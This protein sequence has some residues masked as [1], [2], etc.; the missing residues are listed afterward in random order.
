MSRLEVRL[1]DRKLWATGD[2]L[3]RAELDLLLNDNAGQGE[4][5]TFL[6]DSGTEMTTMPAWLAK[7]WT[8]PCPGRRPLVPSTSRPG[9]RSVR[10][11]SVRGSLA[12]TAWTSISLASSW[13]IRTPLP[14]SAKPRP[15]PESSWDSLALWTRYESSSTAHRRQRHCTGISFS[16]PAPARD[17]QLRSDATGPHRQGQATW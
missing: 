2:V 8:S 12:W 7:K 3:L 5:D 10:D 1:R 15:G 11:C 9:W 4:A 6:V 17:G 16:R 13:V 14:A